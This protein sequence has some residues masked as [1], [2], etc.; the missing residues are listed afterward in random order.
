[1]ALVPNEALSGKKREQLLDVSTSKQNAAAV[2]IMAKIR[3]AAEFFLVDYEE[4]STMSETFA[5]DGSWH[6]GYDKYCEVRV[7][8][9]LASEKILL[10]EGYVLLVE[11][12]VVMKKG[13]GGTKLEFN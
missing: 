9:S 1:M 7:K 8:K 10:E 13:N 2:G 6:L 5:E 3:I 12:D 4:T 11:G